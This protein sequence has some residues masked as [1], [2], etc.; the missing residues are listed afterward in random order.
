MQAKRTALHLAARNGHTE[1]VADLLKAGADVNATDQ[2]GMTALHRAAANGSTRAAGELV[3]A[4]AHVDAKLQ[5]THHCVLLDLCA[6]VVGFGAELL[7]TAVKGSYAKG[8]LP[9]PSC[10]LDNARQVGPKTC[11]SRV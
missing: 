1:V 5:V 2:D 9:V 10:S 3:W 11:N 4:H 6:V 7:N 8:M